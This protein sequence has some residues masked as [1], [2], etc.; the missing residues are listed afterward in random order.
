[1]VGRERAS[2][3][4]FARAAARI[5]DLDE[6]LIEPVSTDQLVQIAPRPL[7]AGLMVEKVEQVL[8]RSMMDYQAGLRDMLSMRGTHHVA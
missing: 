4:D 5:F 8:G 6:T 2:R 7:D 3:F 1:M